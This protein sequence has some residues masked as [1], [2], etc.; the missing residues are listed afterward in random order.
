M[1]DIIVKENFFSEDLIERLNVDLEKLSPGNDFIDPVG[2]WAG[3]LIANQ[4][5]LTRDEAF[6]SSVKELIDLILPVFESH[7]FI[8]AISYNKLYL[9]WDIHT[10]SNRRQ[11]FTEKPYYNVL[12]PLHSV[13][14]RTI[15]FNEYSEDYNEFFK[16]KQTNNKSINPVSLEIWNKYLDMCWDDDRLWLSIK[17]ILPVQNAGQFIAF[18]RKFFHS[19]DNFHKRINGPKRFLQIIVDRA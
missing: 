6:N 3:Q 14:S 5:P 13:D 11:S 15:I 10:D 9:P 8:S 4:R 1:D 17:N 7:S 19:S 16:F 18:K 2:I 12:I